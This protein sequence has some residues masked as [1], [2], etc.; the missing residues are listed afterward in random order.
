V[1]DNWVNKGGRAIVAAD[2]RLGRQEAP[3]LCLIFDPGQ[4]PHL[5]ALETAGASAADHLTS[6]SIIHR[7]AAE[8]GWLELLANGLSFDCRGLAP[9]PSEP[10][11]PAGIP[12]GL[13]SLPGGEVVS[14][15]VGPHLAG[16]SGLLPVLRTLAGLGAALGQLPGLL[17]IAWTPAHSWVAPDQFVRAVSDWLAGGAFPALALTS[18]EREGNGA[19][20]SHGLALITGQE[21][22]FEPDKHLSAA[23]MA[24]IAVRLI[25][26]LVQRGPLTE[27]QDFVS[28]EG[29]SVLVVPVRE[30]TQL[31]AIVRDTDRTR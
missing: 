5:A 30:G 12:V 6:F 16:A 28:P 26:E 2:N 1:S 21:L 13:R 25:H 14:L 8:E 9:A 24:R 29:Q 3:R 11:P 19:L 17:A 7:S 20:V 10:L 31:R 4:R 18:I 27:G 15:G 23:A 22:R